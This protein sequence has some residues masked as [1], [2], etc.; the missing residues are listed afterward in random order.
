MVHCRNDLC[1]AV[2]WP[3]VAAEKADVGEINGEVLPRWLFFEAL[4]IAAR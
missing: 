2:G 4:E 1:T 3:R